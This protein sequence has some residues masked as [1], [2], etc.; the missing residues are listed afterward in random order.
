MNFI[1]GIIDV[2]V[3]IFTLNGDKIL[4][5]FGKM[6]EGV[7]GLFDAGLGFVTGIFSADMERDQ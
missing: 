3:G 6:W 5:G 2:I 4:E 1:S 7:K